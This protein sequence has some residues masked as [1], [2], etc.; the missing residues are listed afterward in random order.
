MVL[1]KVLISTGGRF[2]KNYFKDDL[3]VGGTITI[4]GIEAMEIT[5]IDTNE[6]KITLSSSNFILK[7][8]EVK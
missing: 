5:D 4:R 3:V 1:Y 6:N 7:V 2:D 8:K